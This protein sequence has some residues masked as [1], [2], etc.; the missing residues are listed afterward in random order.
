MLPTSLCWCINNN[1]T[2]FTYVFTTS[3]FYKHFFQ[4]SSSITW[5]CT[6]LYPLSTRTFSWCGSSLWNSRKLYKQLLLKRDAELFIEI[7][8]QCWVFNCGCHKRFKQ[9]G[10]ALLGTGLSCRTYVQLALISEPMWCFY[11]RVTRRTQQ[12]TGLSG[13]TL[14]LMV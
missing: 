6:A 2:I 3:T 5:K 1:Y 7:S 12:T 10:D 14:K 13:L 11:M 4:H 8:L 9:S